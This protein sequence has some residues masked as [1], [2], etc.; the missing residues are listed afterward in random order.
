MASTKA[1]NLGGI[2][3]ITAQRRAYQ[4]GCPDEEHTRS[5]VCK[6]CDGLFAFFPV[7]LDR[8]YHPQRD[9][10]AHPEIDLSCGELLHFLGLILSMDT[11]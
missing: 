4:H 1:K 9:K 5:L 10:K 8:R 2:A 11:V 3:W 7:G 6:L